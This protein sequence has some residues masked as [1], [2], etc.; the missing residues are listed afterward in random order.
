MCIEEMM[1]MRDVDVLFLCKYHMVPFTGSLQ[2][3]STD[4]RCNGG[5]SS[6]KGCSSKGIY[7]EVTGA[8]ATDSTDC[9]CGGGC[10]VVEG[11]GSDASVDFFV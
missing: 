2:A 7:K 8:G 10:S 1:I 5:G 11:W 4:C 6:A 3:G 9:G